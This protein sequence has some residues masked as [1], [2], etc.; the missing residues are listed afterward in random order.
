[1]K[2]CRYKFNNYILGLFSLIIV[3]VL[4]IISPLLCFTINELDF[5]PYILILIS[6][7][8]ILYEFAPIKNATKILKI[9][10]IAVY[11]SSIIFLAADIIVFIIKA[12]TSSAYNFFDYMLIGYVI[13]PIV[14]TIIE[15][16]RSIKEY[17]NQDDNNNN[18]NKIAVGNT[19]CL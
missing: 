7:F 6:I 13:V 2:T 9:E 16:A 15:I 14:V 8:G 4:P 5:M 11:V 17:I 12:D 19:A 3:C 18:D 1:M 10:T